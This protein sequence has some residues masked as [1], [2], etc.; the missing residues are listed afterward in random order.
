MLLTANCVALITDVLD[1]RGVFNVCVCVCIPP[2]SQQAEDR[3][4]SS[5]LG[6]G[7]F[8]IQ[9]FTQRRQVSCDNMIYVYYVLN[10]FHTV[11]IQIE[12]MNITFASLICIGC[13]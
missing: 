11:F 13:S 9:T 3:G 2:V 1:A 7:Y 4:D 5:D 10:G 6:S 12:F 8:L